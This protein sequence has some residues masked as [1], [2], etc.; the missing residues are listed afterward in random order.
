MA[1]TFLSKR[2]LLIAMAKYRS[3]IVQKSMRTL[4]TT[5][6]ELIATKFPSSGYLGLVSDPM[7]QGSP[8]QIMMSNEFEPT[9]LLIPIDPLPANGR[10]YL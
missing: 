5:P 1:P 4:Y 10:C 3:N 2:N 7:S 9:E 6:P 8:M